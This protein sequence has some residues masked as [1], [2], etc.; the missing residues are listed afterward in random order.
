MTQSLSEYLFER[1]CN[2]R[3]IP[4]KRIPEA[5]TK[6]P[7]YELFLTN[8]VVVEVKEIEPSAEELESERLA[9]ERGWGNAVG[10]TPGDRIRLK[11]AASS[12]QIKARTQGKH[13][14]LLVVFNEGRE[15]PHLE[16]YSV[17]VAMYGLEQMHIAVPA[18]GNG[19]PY[20]T[21][22]GYGPKRKMTPTHNTSI[23]AI[24]ALVMNSHEDIVLL[25]YH[26]KYARVRLP[27]AVL[28]PYGIRQFELGHDV[29][30]TTA[31]WCAIAPP[32]P[33]GGAS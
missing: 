13:P 6:T 18:P 10:H 19:S 2:E 24:G 11:I 25:V 23:S 20:A 31:D 4:W 28:G 14:S 9:Q 21:G 30:G 27:P 3:G 33:E 12:K 15:I 7:D 29:P 32:G 5:G 17:R 22:M 16:S 1:F 8:S 26:N